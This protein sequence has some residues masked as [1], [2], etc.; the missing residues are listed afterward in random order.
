MNISVR[1]INEKRGLVP[2]FL[3]RNIFQIIIIGRRYLTSN[4]K[5]FWFYDRSCGL[6]IDAYCDNGLDFF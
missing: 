1:L 3:Y 2:L 5:G 4:K 6:S